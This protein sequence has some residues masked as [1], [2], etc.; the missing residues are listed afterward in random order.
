MATCSACGYQADPLPALHWRSGRWC[1]GR[2]PIGEPA[3]Q[4]EA[5]ASSA[6]GQPSS[7]SGQPA[8]EP[9]SAGEAIP[10]DPI[11][12]LALPRVYAY[13]RRVTPA[14]VRAALLALGDDWLDR[15]ERG[16]LPASEAYRI[17]RDRM[18]ASIEL[19]SG[20]RA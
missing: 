12:A 9:C 7:A 8:S 14:D 13:G 11:A 5:P 16:E 19:R 17:A 2:G 6:S 3:S 10:A 4:P 1:D 20:R 15:F 18:R